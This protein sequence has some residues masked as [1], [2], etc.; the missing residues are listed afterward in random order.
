MSGIK[1][2]LTI[3]L[4][5]ARDG[6][7]RLGARVADMSPIWDDIGS[8]MVRST[9]RRFETGTGPDGRAW[10][11]S[12]RVLK[13]GG[14][15]LVD[16]KHLLGSLTHVADGEGAEWG[17][18]V[19]YAAMMNFGGSVTHHARSQ[20][21]YYKYDAKTGE[22][23]KFVKKSRANFERWGTI[24]EYSVTMPARPFMGVSGDDEAEIDAII[25]DALV[26]AYGGA[27]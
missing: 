3:D 7:A 16:T 12:K 22:L 2:E 19:V 26:L 6:L 25:G 17:S 9:Q 23:G 13:R 1:I 20:K 18:S 15:T 27:S 14:Q 24:P 11:P 4:Q 5:S 10:T 21:Q 8:A